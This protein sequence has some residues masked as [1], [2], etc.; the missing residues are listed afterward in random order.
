MKTCFYPPDVSSRFEWSEL[1]CLCRYLTAEVWP[2]YIP[3][4]RR[5][6]RRLASCVI[7][8]GFNS[9]TE[10]DRTKKAKQSQAAA[11]YL[12]A[13]AAVGQHFYC[14]T[15]QCGRARPRGPSSFCHLK[16]KTTHYLTSGEL[17]LQPHRVLISDPVMSGG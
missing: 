9:S 16:T 15:A 5:S 7:C 12:T 14:H 11:V 13:P 8:P 17:R 6:T 2:F 3:F 4:P 1:G 10:I